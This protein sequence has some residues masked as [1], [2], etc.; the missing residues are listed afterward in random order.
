MT[1]QEHLLTCLSEECAEVSKVVSKMLRFGVDD[2]SPHLDKD[3][4]H[5][6]FDE[7]NDL[8]AVVEMLHDVDIHWRIDNGAVIDKKAKVEKWM[9]HAKSRGTLE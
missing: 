1:K 9:R 4:L 7:L 8:F 3:N 5:L 2:Q 6:L